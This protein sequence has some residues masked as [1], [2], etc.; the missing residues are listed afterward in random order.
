MAKIQSLLGM[1]WDFSV[2]QETMDNRSDRW[3]AGST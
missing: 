1:S 3:V 2:I